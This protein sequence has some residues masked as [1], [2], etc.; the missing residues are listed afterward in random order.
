MGWGASKNT[1]T[2]GGRG[3]DKVTNQERRKEKALPV[4]RAA[5]CTKIVNS[6]REVK[7]GGKKQREKISRNRGKNQ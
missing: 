2:G 5:K 3:S 7:R 1:T 6:S 4:H